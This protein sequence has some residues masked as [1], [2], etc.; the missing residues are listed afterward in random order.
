MAEALKE[1]LELAGHQVVAATDALVAL[2]IAEQLVPEV[3]IL[4]IELPIMDGY[5]L[6]GHL[7]EMPRV[8][9][10]VLVAVTG[11]SQ[12]YDRHR[13]RN[14]GFDH[15]LVKPVDLTGSPELSTERLL[16]A[17]KPA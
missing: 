2:E 12:Q 4:D 6:A 9:S 8:K 10:S 17:A 1:R 7:R 14:A 11:Y 15:Y 3:C 5:E 16:R 13:T